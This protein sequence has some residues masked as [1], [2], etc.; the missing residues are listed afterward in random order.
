MFKC[1]SLTTNRASK[2]ETVSTSD[3]LMISELLKHI[4]HASN[5]PLCMVITVNHSA[6]SYRLK[7]LDT[8]WMETKCEVQVLLILCFGLAHFFCPLDAHTCEK[9]SLYFSLIVKGEHVG[10]EISTHHWP[11]TYLL[12]CPLVVTTVTHKPQWRAGNLD[13]GFRLSGPSLRTS[14][15]PRL[16]KHRT[17]VDVN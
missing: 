10:W 3:A 17:G 5:S 14:C 12:W 9:I 6:V 15:H 4:C 13:R 7:C 2:E 11:F 8:Y 1:I 16:I